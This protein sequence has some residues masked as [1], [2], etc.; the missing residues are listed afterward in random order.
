MTL[1][2][3]FSVGLVVRLGERVFD[4]DRRLNDDTVIFVDA[5]D[6]T[7]HCWKLGDTYRDIANG[8][9]A[10]V[11]GD[12]S[13]ASSDKSKELPL[14]IDINSLPEKHRKKLNLQFDYIH[15]M[16]RLGLS[17]GQRRGVEQALPKL[18]ERFGDLAPPSVSA[19]LTW[20]RKLESSDNVITSLVS[21]HYFKKPASRKD[22]AVKLIQR[23]IRLE[24]CNSKRLTIT[25]VTA[26]INEKLAVEART[27][28]V[29]QAEANVSY[30]TV[31]RYI[32]QIDPYQLDAARFTVSYAKNRW[33]Y[34][35]QGT[36]CS[37][38]MER[39]EIDH[40]ILD[41]VVVSD[42]NGMPLGRPTITV[43]VDTYSSYVVGFFVS[44]W[45]TGLATTLSSLKVAFGPKDCFMGAGLKVQHQWLSYG[46]CE[47]LVM[48]NGLEFH[49][50]QMNSVARHLDMDM[51]FCP[52]RTP[53]LKPVVERTLG[54]LNLYLPAQGR[55]E[56]PRD[57]YIPSQSDKTCCVPFSALCE[58]LLMAFV[59]VH[60]FEINERK[61]ARPVDLI[62]ES[63]EKLPPPCLP[64][65]MTQLDILVGQ[66]ES[67]LIG[68]EGIVK[69]Y[70]RYNSPELQE[71]R[72]FQ[73][74]KFK[75][76]MRYDPVNLDQVFVRV[77]D[78]AEWL[79]VPS[80]MPD[81]TQGLSTVQHKAIRDF[82]K[83]ELTRKGAEETLIRA[84][85]NL[86]DH[87][88]SAV[89]VGKRLKAQQ[90]KAMEGLTSAC[91][92]QPGEAIPKKSADASVSVPVCE[93]DMIPPLSEVPL[94]TTEK[95]A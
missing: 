49:S 43:V 33:R 42:H 16:R 3:T 36:N 82:S 8:R 63:L 80:C 94:F 22:W 90:L 81:Y 53:W 1:R 79:V 35:L 15:A 11:R 44:F 2:F 46:I 73:G 75:T 65:P 17:R 66:S 95:F 87:W 72:R 67:R 6:K 34:S 52:V 19:V 93:A 57:N 92:H 48:D 7:P 74:T 14:L 45:G 32:K 60:P 54:T 61:L 47:L 31:R 39:Y 70:L 85:K 64:G 89:R 20:W 38:A 78:S 41:I 40:T 88:A 24:Y 86:N 58:G 51:L 55:V 10:L 56:K 29:G 83:G 76:E 28:G 71:V 23:T 77:P 12:H 27:I 5:I 84:K 59:D 91:L 30:N 69:N 37:R 25:R 26:L 18:A 68:N 4:F 50:P 9:L 13:G 21:G 62:Q